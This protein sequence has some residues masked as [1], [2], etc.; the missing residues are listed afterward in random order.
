MQ[1]THRARAW[2]GLG[3]LSLTLTQPV[4]AASTCP[5]P[6]PIKAPADFMWGLV[7]YHVPLSGYELNPADFQKMAANGI[8]WISVDFA[9]KRIEP[10]QGAR[11]ISAT[12]TW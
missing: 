2:L 12:S 5:N 9:W 8:K 1:P 11:T 3:L 10:T 6:M 7:A 4:L